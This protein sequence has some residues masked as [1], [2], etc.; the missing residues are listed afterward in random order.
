MLGTTIGGRYQITEHLGGGGFGQTFLAID[1]HLP[2]KPTCVVKQLK[3]QVDGQAAWQAATRLFDREAEVLYQLGN[4]DQIPRLFAHFEEN[5][6]FYLVQ[7]FVEGR[8]LNKAIKKNACWA[9][10]DVIDFLQDVL[11]TLAFVHEQQV[12]HRDIKPSNLIRRQSDQKIVLIDFGAVKHIGSQPINLEEDTTFTIAVGSSGYMP[13]EQLAGRPRYCSDVYSLGIVGIQMLTGLS[14]SKLRYDARTGELIWRDRSKTVSPEL[15]DILDLMVRYDYR[16]RYQSATEALAALQTLATPKHDTVILPTV[17]SAVK[18]V[19]RSNPTLGDREAPAA[20]H[21]DAHFAW[22]ERADELFQ[23]QRY[24]KAVECYDKVIQLT[25]NDYLAWFKRGIA[26]ENLHQYENA[27]TSYQ[28]VIEIQP[29]DYLAWFKRGKALEQLKRYPEALAAYDRVIQVQP[30]NY[31]A[32]HDRGK[33]LE[34]SGQFDEALAAYDRAVHLKPDFP[35]AVESRKRLLMERCDVDQLYHLQHYQ[36]AIAACTRTLRDDP[37]NA[38]AWLMQGMAL[39]NLQ[40]YREAAAAY[41]KVVQLHGDDHIA[42]FKLAALLERLQKYKEAAAAYA[43]VSQLQPHN[44]WAWHD[45]GR[46]LEKMGQYEAAIAAYDHALRINADFD[47]AQA[48]R[49]RSLNQIKQQAQ[50]ASATYHPPTQ[51]VV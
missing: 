33:V 37:S 20:Q 3:P 42:W 28:R 40:R 31:W 44:Q 16:Q 9:E 10:S 6:E 32:W 24:L 19:K 1:R 4:H 25:P 38:N 29:D 5:R 43:K 46:S 12:I 35:V 51:Y 26:F 47:S 13:N 14:P 49:Q 21:S 39:E 34:Q 8:V 48:G 22:F 45:R 27:A 23:Q 7:E 15:A 30:G 36:E 50:Q 18:A 17:N 11:T 2:G 41:S